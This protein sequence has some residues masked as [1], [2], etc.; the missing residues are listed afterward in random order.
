M[1]LVERAAVVACL[2]VCPLLFFTDLTRN[3]YITQITLLNLAIL[4]AAG[5]FLARETA[6]LR[7]LRTPIELPLAAWAG[8]CLLS[9]LVSYAGHA[10]F[11]RPAI[12]NEGLRNGVFLVV[13][14]F[15][16]F[17]IAVAAARQSQD[18]SAPAL[19]PWIVV[20]VGWGALWLL[21]PQLRGPGAAAV[22]TWGLFWDGYGALVWAVGVAG[23]LWLCRKGRAIDFLHLGVA[24]GFLAS[25]Y[26]VLQYF[27]VELIWPHALNPYGGRSV[28][29]FGNPNF[30]SSYLVLALPLAVL[31]FVRSDGRRRLAYA[32]AALTMEAALLCS[33]TRSSWIGAL[34]AV[35]ALAASADVRKAIAED[36][37]PVGLLAGI[38]LAMAVL[39]PQSLINASYEP[40]V[41][42]RVKEIGA[43]LKPG[44]SY[45]PFHQR[46]LIWR[47]AWMMGRENPL[48]GKG[49][50]LFEL[51]Y[52]FYQGPILVAA[53][54]FRNMR[55]HAN[56][57][58]DEILEVF[59]QTGLVGL[60][61]YAW[62]WVAFFRSM[63]PRL[64]KDALGDG[65][66]VACAAGAAGMLIDN[67]LNVSLHFAVPAFWF[68]WLV[69]TAV[70]ANGS[71]AG[72]EAEAA[73]AAAAPA[74]K[75]EA[76]AAKAPAAAPPV[77]VRQLGL[78]AAFLVLAWFGWYYVRVWVREVDYFAGFKLLREGQGPA[79]V[80]ELEESKRWGPPEV[81]AIYELG[82]AYARTNQFAQAAQTYRDALDANTGYDEIFFNLAAVESGHLG[83]VDQAIDDFRM[84]WWIN[85]LSNEIYNSL[86][87]LLLHEPAK[88]L[89]DA[90]FYLGKAV[91][92]FPDNPAHWNNLGYAETLAKDYPAAE[93]A[94]IQALTIDPSLSVAEQNL[95]VLAKRVGG[96]PP[97]ILVRLN[98]LRD[99]DARVAKRDFSDA[100]LALAQ[101]LSREF[102]EMPKVQFLWGSLLLQ[103]RRPDQAVAPL[104]W[105][106][107][108]APDNSWAHS[109]LGE[110]Y[111]LL[112]RRDDAVRE[113]RAALS[114]DPNNQRA[115]LRLKQLGA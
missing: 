106:V 41:I 59:S 105:V 86:D 84:A 67:L 100:T 82:N 27:N 21:F 96:P 55:T 81:N 43:L 69:G 114:A 60:G 17:F 47:C 34:V 115:A 89:D 109:N 66:V 113:L 26:G 35:A 108:H 12:V 1:R 5:A 62:L 40:S 98:D 90:L 83:Q 68:W 74:K 31:W 2:F 57:A 77:A 42:G 7:R 102:P 50:G 53:D 51:F 97:P 63:M 64:K 58:H 10:A 36:P 76:K 70:G 8:A 19:G 85:P 6:P 87:N 30:M 65:A 107:A 14:A 54:F 24:A 75:K 101:K 103:R 73:P 45:S 23:V 20:T 13:N 95:A 79:A 15:L 94:Y 39:W 99:L 110:A 104:E 18:W 38:G 4:V 92:F 93:R 3:P 48:T 46:V 78:A 112:N 72:S 28:S 44:A 49:F 32:V 61:A 111:L 80:H 71:P 25:A 33:L 29:T 37:R 9:W 16:V 52:P 11:F 56:N 22:D 91:H 88:H